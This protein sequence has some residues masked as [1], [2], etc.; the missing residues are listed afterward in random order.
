[1]AVP[2]HQQLLEALAKVDRPESF[3][4]TG[5]F[6]PVL[7]GLEARALGRSLCRSEKRKP[8]P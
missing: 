2:I 8:R 3:C 4:V 7:P 6:P 5:R 1:M